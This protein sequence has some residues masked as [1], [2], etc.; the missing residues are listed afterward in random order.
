MICRFNGANPATALRLGFSG[1]A[2]VSE[3]HNRV[4]IPWPR[5]L[6]DRIRFGTISG[7]RRSLRIGSRRQMLLASI[8]LTRK[9]QQ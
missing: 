1:Q 5:A 6:T 2:P 7:L 3:A 4:A 8:D 9:T